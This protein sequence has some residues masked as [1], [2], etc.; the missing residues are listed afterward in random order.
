MPDSAHVAQKPNVGAQTLARGLKVL[1]LLVNET[2]PQRPA[3]IA[4]ALE[5]ERNAVYR[6]LRELESN[7]FVAREAESGRYTIGSGLVGL[8]ARVMRRVDL[9]QSAKPF[10]EQMGQ[11]SGE[12][13][14][15]HVRH[16]R[17]RICVDTVPGRHT[18]SRVVE[19]GENLP[20]HAGPSGKAILA[21]IEPAEM[22]SI[23]EEATPDQGEQVKLYD[24]LEGIRGNGYLATVGDRSPGVGGLS[25]PFF[26]ADGIVGALTISGPAS[27]WTH[28]A[29]VEFAPE[30]VTASIEL[31]LALG[32]RPD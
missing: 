10:M 29:Q 22:A 12:T 21:F 9:R 13:I 11:T 25:A 30:L 1:T 2:S 31:S 14:S 19:I 15:I 6:L 17:R 7:S 24:L 26:N 23:V 16:G 28:E 3:E 27:R 4:Q 32:H 5:L 20:L 18:V 8:S